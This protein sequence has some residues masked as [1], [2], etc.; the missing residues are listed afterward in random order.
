MIYDHTI[1]ELLLIAGA[2]QL[3][4]V[5]GAATVAAIAIYIDQITRCE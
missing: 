5:V 3:T 2:V 4:I 1:T